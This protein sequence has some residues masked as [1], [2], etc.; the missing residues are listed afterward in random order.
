METDLEKKINQIKYL[1]WILIGII[2]CLALFLVTRYINKPFIGFNDWNSNLWT[3]TAKNNL[4]YGVAC[5]KLG[6]S[7][8]YYPV[9]TCAGLQ[10][11]EN[12][13][14]L[15]SW[16][17]T[18]FYALFGLSEGVG[19]LPFA[20]FSIGSAL[21]VFAIGKLLYNRYV[22]FFASLFFIATPLFQFFSKEIY[23]DPLVLFGLLWAVYSYSLWI[24]KEK[25]KYYYSF[26][27]SSL[28]SAMSGWQVYFVYPIL[29]ILTFIY[30]RKYFLKSL[31]PVF[32]L[33][34]VF[35]GHQWHIYINSG[36]WQ[37]NEMWQ[38][39][40]VRANLSKIVAV[41][42]NFSNDAVYFTFGD[43]FSR[44]FVRISRYFTWPLM[45]LGWLAMIGFFANLY[46]KRKIEFQDKIILGLF[47]TSW[48]IILFFSELVYIHDFLIIYLLPTFALFTAVFINFIRKYTSLLEYSLI[49][50]IIV[51][52]IFWT[53]YKDVQYLHTTNPNISMQLISQVINKKG[54]QYK[55]FVQ[56][57]IMV[58][59]YPAVWNYAYGVAMLEAQADTFQ[60]F[61]Q[62]EK[63]V[64]NKYDYLLTN[65]LE[66]LD[67]NFIKYLDGKYQ[68]EIINIKVS[69]PNNPLQVQW[70]PFFLYNLKEINKS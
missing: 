65:N 40:M 30:F 70:I 16:I 48:I 69:N 45:L 38:Q 47:I 53:G 5:T 8:T 56:S 28:F 63:Q 25:S 58:Y 26:L 33:V 41:D 68:K 27:L 54:L 52:A 24:K 22:G 18:L 44:I 6:Q 39:L 62:R 3:V 32:I 37:F 20:L 19:R 4:K 1:D 7:T 2:T 46:Q 51:I 29:V 31:V 11:Y 13:P 55:Y 42:K 57:Q 21:M 12:Y 59:Q 15:V 49:N 36:S 67:P 9:Q 50:L 10:Y 17:P 66:P 61:K 64:S 43:F 35:I 34:L 23:H 14:P 60:T